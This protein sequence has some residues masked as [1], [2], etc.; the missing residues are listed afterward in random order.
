MTPWIDIHLSGSRKISAF[1]ESK[2]IGIPSFWVV[3]YTLRV[4]VA[5]DGFEPVG[6]SQ[7]L[8]SQKLLIYLACGLLDILLGL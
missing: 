5:T 4:I 2:F 6:M 8:L 1:A 7:P 3:G